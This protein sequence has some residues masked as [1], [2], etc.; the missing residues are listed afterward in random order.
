MK[1]KLWRQI[2]SLIL[3]LILVLEL[4][5]ASVLATGS[6]AEQ[7][8]ATEEATNE[9]A[10]IV[11]EVNELREEAVKHFRMSDGSY[12]LV[13]YNEPV[14]Y[15]D[16]DEE[17]QE[18]DNTLWKDGAEYVSENGAV[19]KAFSA[20]LASGKLFEISYR[21]HGLSMTLL[22]QTSAVEELEE[23]AS[24]TGEPAPEV[25]A[26]PEVDQAIT[27][28]DNPAAETAEVED[29][30]V[31][32]PQET[33]EL[34]LDEPAEAIRFVPVEAEQ[35]QA[36]V[37]NPRT[38]RKA[39][40]QMSRDEGVAVDKIV[41]HVR[42]ADVL[43]HTSLA[44]SSHG[45]NIK[46]S[47]LIQEK[48]DAYSYAF[49]LGLTNVTPVLQEDGSVHLNDG[50][51]NTVFVIPAP[52]MQDANGITSDQA[53][54]TLTETE[55]GWVLTVTAD[56]EWL[57]AE[58][59]AF[60]V[61]L[62]P[63]VVLQ[64]SSYILTACTYKGS[65][66]TPS[67]SSAMH[68][69]YSVD[70]RLGSCVVYAQLTRLPAIPT[71]C[72]PVASYLGLYH[73]GFFTS[74]DTGLNYP[75][76]SGLLTVTAQ[77]STKTL[78]DIASL[79]SVFITLNTNNTI[80]D[81]ARLT[82]DTVNTYVN[83][84]ITPEAM[85]WYENNTIN[86]GIILQ[87][88]QGVDEA[89]LSIL[90][91][92]GDA[93]ALPYFAVVYR[94]AAGL[95]DY[96]TYQEAS[97]ARAGDVYISDFTTQ[98]TA[99]HTDLS[100]ASE[101]TPFT[102]RHVYN[103]ALS[104][105]QFT[106]S[107]I[108]NTPSFSSMQLGY[109]WKLSAQQTVT[110][111]ALDGT[112]YLIYND[113]DGTEHYF[114]QLEDNPKVYEDE[115]GLNLKLTESTDGGYTVYT[116]TDK[117]AENTWVFY[118]G[119]LIST[120]DA[121]GNAI[122][123]AYNNNYSASNTLWKP[124]GTQSSK[125][126]VQIVSVPKG[127]SPSVICS[128]SYSGSDLAKITDYAGR[129]IV[130][131]Y[132]TENG[133]RQLKSIQR[134]DGTNSQ[135]TYDSETGRMSALFDSEAK[136]GLGITQ[137]YVLGR[138]ATNQICEF[139]A[140]SIDG[141]R[142]VGNAFHAYRNSPQMTSYRFYGPDHTS[143]TS[144][145]VVTY[146]IFD[147]I[148]RTVCAYNTNYNKATVIGATAAAYTKNSGTAKNNNRLTGAA[149]LGLE[150]YNSLE[151]GG[152]EVGGT[153]WYSSGGGAT[154]ASSISSEKT[155]TGQGAL[156]CT[157][158][159]SASTSSV[160]MRQSVL[161]HAFTTY[162]LTGYI[163]T[164]KLTDFSSTSGGAYLA[165]LNGTT[166]LT[167][168]AKSD[169]INYA[170]SEAVNGDDDNV[171]LGWEK[172]S[173]SFQ[174]AATGLY[175]VAFVQS[176]AKGA[177]Y[178]DDLQ[179]DI[180]RTA[181]ITDSNP[182][183]SSVNMVQW[184][185]ANW[186]GSGFTVVDSTN[187]LANKSA[188]TTGE[189]E[190]KKR[191]TKTVNINKPAKNLTF[192]L[193]GWAQAN[194]VTTA[195][196]EPISSNWRY[197][198]LI[199]VIHY[200]DGTT[201][202]HYVSFNKD[203][204][205]W[206]FT[207]G[208]VVPK[209]ENKTIS[210]IDVICAYD[211]NQNTARFNNVSF[212]RE[213]VQT[214]VYDGEGNPVAV[215]DGNAKTAYEYVDDSE[216]LKNYT[217]PSGTK[218]DM[219]YYENHLL[220]T[221][222]LAG[223][224]TTT[225]EYNGTGSITKQTV[226]GAGSNDRLQADY[227]YS[228]D[229]QFLTSSTSVNGDQTKYTHDTATRQ[230]TAVEQ[231]DGVVR[232]MQY[233]FSSDRLQSTSIL[234]E[235]SLAY[236]YQ[237]GKLSALER[238]SFT[239]AAENEGEFHQ[240]YLIGSDQFGNVQ[241]IRVSGTSGDPIILASYEYEDNVNNGRLAQL[242]YANGDTVDY[243]YDLFDR[244]TKET[245]KDSTLSR[246]AIFHYS[247]DGNGN[248]IEQK[249]TNLAG[250][251]TESYSYQY[252]SLGRLI[253]SRRKD[254]SGDLVLS[255]SHLYDTS[256]RLTQQRWQFGS[257]DTY[258]QTFQY[259]NGADGDGTLQS[260]EITTPKNGSIALDYTYNPLRQLT[261]RASS[262]GGKEF[263][264]SFSYQSIA[265]NRKSNQIGEAKYTFDGSVKLGYTYKYDAMDRITEVRKSG[266][267]NSQYLEYAYDKLGQLVSATD[268]AAGLEY[269]YTFD[270]AGNVLSAV[271][272]P[273]SD[274]SD[275]TRTYHYDNASWRDLLTSITINGT[276]KSI[277]YPHD[278]RG[279]IT[280]GTPLSWYNG[281]EFT[282]TWGKGT[283]LASAKK[284]LALKTSYTYDI[285]GVRSSKTVGTTKYSFTTLSGLVMRQEWGARQM[286]FVY[287]ENNQP[288]ALSYKSGKNVAPVMYY[289]LLNQQG[290]V[291]ALM[292]ANGAIVATYE[293]DP[294]GAVTVKNASGAL[295]NDDTSIGNMN[296]LRYRGY[297]YDN[298]TGFYYLESR[299]YDPVVG[300][301]I[302]PDSYASTGQGA[303]GC[304]MFAYCENDP[305]LYSDPCG[306][307]RM[308]EGYEPP[309]REPKPQNKATI[310][311]GIEGSAAFGA[312][313]TGGAQVVLDTGS[314]DIA[315]IAYGGFGGG[316][317]SASISGTFTYTS[318][319]SLDQLGGFGLA[320][321]GSIVNPVSLGGEMIFGEGYSGGTGSKGIGVPYPEL[322]GEITY[323]IVWNITTL[324]KSTGWYEDVKNY[325]IKAND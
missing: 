216:R 49:G 161:L 256:N 186:S 264:R 200:T 141:A 320:I 104:G 207:S 170:T 13:E 7:G 58:G 208:I 128:F 272:H 46:E 246:G 164:S 42:Y 154:G 235:A 311:V 64:G 315:L 121:V 6:D 54:Y 71:N 172:V 31:E 255:T 173:V 72:V 196:P 222:V 57:N 125:R 116:M 219:T 251:R 84:D 168:A 8:T 77:A 193:S 165:F 312:R 32:V 232:S 269:T 317:P 183:A 233:D 74:S 236:S 156:K 244:V 241:T 59:R 21:N 234:P 85:K 51:S 307:Y 134:T 181:Y 101:A 10:Y 281:N 184:D 294:W 131:S 92:S 82:K 266:S 252:D 29:I 132:A 314:G 283:Q 248:L 206:Q 159:S 148:G 45:N 209:E 129:Q 9:E 197:F 27:G 78:D 167:T 275:S 291:E 306:T 163:N 285:A 22:E 105:Q 124:S 3:S 224:F 195:L 211:H 63:S 11:S 39:A 213:P 79:T 178:C 310:G 19:R 226:R 237:W 268:H 271:K 215:T 130:F 38:V 194:S 147:N 16:A 192:I 126:I 204:T 303:L 146:Y 228:T 96:Y 160:S 265:V 20:T 286:D 149:S 103:S 109:G 210:T 290:D 53:E 293:Y 245:Y 220:K 114:E 295:D 201:E 308:I 242:E 68:C 44:Y 18:I 227:A 52:W 28:E 280:A 43:E 169:V 298:E 93:G 250:T 155:R 133:R 142:T 292:D 247:Y 239:N 297:Y 81:F 212:V 65:I 171:D 14:H 2:L 157:S 288:Y 176:G 198:G 62:D 111:K 263:A 119:Y 274:G 319:K 262:V 66:L 323:T 260:V 187:K 214:Y 321:G 12:L 24:E 47:I 318:A 150:P 296:P 305:I 94:N 35:V 122:Y 203:S 182:V 179:L 231:P 55:D 61:S 284:G 218:H 273:T 37:E 137:R 144:D 108:V 97:A 102:L 151:D 25:E 67:R 48:R 73:G 138:W 95:E 40:G 123:I 309:K 117:G 80:L 5:P 322:H 136:Y 1:S 69:G 205:D 188:E 15:Q 301:F 279:N 153:I 162:T 26:E 175:Q 158:T 276:T 110:P 253:H 229:G 56:A 113:E 143:D 166:G 202:N 23:H 261:E 223:D 191:L 316:T 17:W 112:N 106:A 34:E 225:M 41:S 304:N 289:Y 267:P 89:R 152:A 190:V 258:H 118:N 60:P 50:E 270:T 238:I 99:V 313:I 243:K 180:D 199:A 177:S 88:P 139:T 4:V 86:T 217:T 221:D 259:S 91:G 325:I 300:R 70:E 254:N 249:E 90:G 87:A 120:T 83:W 324:L 185:P 145:D 257:D 33:P 30:A 135:Y 115:D 76:P 75:N 282:L 277:S 230:V 302:S 98:L 278:I 299:Y 127:K 189:I 287:D 107:S 100:Y 240:K 174:P 36:V 140:D